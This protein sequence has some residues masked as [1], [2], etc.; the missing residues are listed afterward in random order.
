MFST[1]RGRKVSKKIILII[2]FLLIILVQTVYSIPQN[3]FNGSPSTTASDYNLS[4]GET[5]TRTLVTDIS[6]S[7]LWTEIDDAPNSDVTI[8]ETSLRFVG[9]GD[10]GGGENSVKVTTLPVT[11]DVCV[12]FT[13]ELISSLNSGLFMVLFDDDLLTASGDASGI[14]LG[15]FG[16]DCV[17]QWCL[18]HDRFTT[19]IATYVAPDYIQNIT[20]CGN[21][22]FYINQTEVANEGNDFLAG[23]LTFWYQTT[24]SGQEFVVRDIF[25]YDR[26]T[27]APQATEE[28]EIVP[29]Y[30]NVTKCME[31]NESG[32]YRLNNSILDSGISKC[33][34]VT[35]NDIILDCQGYTIDGDDA[36]DYGIYIYRDDSNSTNITIKNCNISNWDT[37]GIYMVNSHNNT[38]S[39]TTLFSNL[40]NG[41]FISSSN[42]NTIA[43]VSAVSSGAS[44]VSMILSKWN[45]ILDS[46]LK[47]NSLYDL[48]MLPS[49]S[50]TSENCNHLIKNINGTDNKP[51][52]FFNN[53]P[54]NIKGYNNN[55]SE[56][57]LCNC[58]GSALEGIT[59]SHTDV[60]NNALI[61][62][63]TDNSTFSNLSLSNLRYGLYVGYS[64]NNNFSNLTI[65]SNHLAS[66]YLV[67]SENNTIT[68]SNFAEDSK[69]FAADGFGNNTIYN[70]LFNCTT[71]LSWT[72]S[73]ESFNNWN[74][75]QQEG[76]RIYSISPVIG[77]NYWTNPT[78]TG[79]SDTCTDS[80]TDGFCDNPYNIT[81]GLEITSGDTSWF[82]V[83]YLAYSDEYPPTPPNITLNPNNFFNALNGSF[84]GL[85]SAESALINITFSDDI[86]LFGL[87]FNIS[88]PN[89]STLLNFTNTS[90]SGKN[91]EFVRTID[92]SGNGTQ[93]YYEVTIIAWDSH[94][95]NNIADFK[96][97]KGLNS[98][99]YDSQVK[100]T[101][102]GA[103]WAS[104]E[105]KGDRYTFEFTYLPIFT[106]ETK[107]FYLES[108][109]ELIYIRDS[110]YKGHFVDWNNKKWIDFEGIEG[111]PA[112]TKIAD[113]K[114]RIEFS[115]K[116]SKLVMKSIGGL[117][118]KQE[119]YKYYLINPDIYWVTPTSEKNSFVDTTLYFTLGVNSQFRNR[120]EFRLYNSTHDL[121]DSLNVTN[122][123]SGVYNY[124]GNSSI[125]FVDDVYY[126][127]ATHYD[128][129]NNLKNSTTLT[130]YNIQIDNCTKFST[131]SI[132]Y[133]IYDES[134]SEVI[135]ADV[136]G[137]YYYNISSEKSFSL[138]QDEVSK[139]SICIYPGWET[140]YSNY[141][142]LISNSTYPTRRYEED[143][144]IL[145]NV[146]QNIKLYL[147]DSDSGIYAYY[148]IVDAYSNPLSD[149]LG[150]VERTIGSSTVTIE[151]STS[152]DSG[153]I[154][155]WL[156][157]D[158]NYQ[159]TFSKT[160]YV[161]YTATLRPSSGEI[162]TI[163]LEEEST[164][165]EQS[166]A[167]GIS[168]LFEP[169]ISNLL[170]RT[171]Y[172]FTFNLTTT[173]WTLTGC[174]LYLK[175]TSETLSSTSGIV[176][177]SKCSL[178]I[179]FNTGNQ[180]TIIAEAVYQLNS[181]TNDTVSTQYAVV[182]SYEG[183]F[184]FKNFLDDL[185]AFGN[186]GFNDFTRMI[187]AFIVIFSIVGAASYKY[188]QFREPMPL[189]ILFL[190][191]LFMFSYIGW[192]TVNYE[193][194]PYHI[195]HLPDGWLRQYMMFFVSIIASVGY[196][197][198]EAK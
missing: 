80:D 28:E 21:G 49:S 73:I 27:G 30:T 77:G 157:P 149:V 96:V 173:Y 60:E 45:K 12:S 195:P 187:I 186:L 106:P 81:S 44:G 167:T 84:I 153:L 185:K 189:I 197:F 134:S 41:I 112:I 165:P 47:N 7:E 160:G 162:T 181:T 117:N 48:A 22:T 6:T 19:R 143:L 148:R 72:A 20:I 3:V 146:T 102:E 105:K 103:I 51:I 147:L 122:N 111:S 90:L 24:D 176:N 98:I 180:T 26:L 68:S 71:R 82:S 76:T 183:Q 128:Q 192:L 154:V 171:D 78:G 29:F 9:S 23:N 130:F 92:V 36:A 50:I 116:A 179:E 4:G 94:T 113:N 144:A 138:A 32:E 43:N 156:D 74:T 170:N 139:F 163:T 136:T 64:N 169:A 25:G 91:F 1:R 17:Y 175:N 87:E 196:F 58:D 108:D 55:V 15:N 172:N 151:Q 174:A 155:F 142:L 141:E 42:Y 135:T 107:V 188:S 132:N 190:I 126:L 127:N 115:N 54:I 52:L 114:W 14:F 67:N 120:T 5:F 145:T 194:I 137:T 69:C 159:F 38:I 168:Y 133:T 66:F 191:L 39:N 57:I 56:I 62:S 85:A 40:D 131:H 104:T 118:S 161:T 193:G 53:T 178:K 59:I 100:I 158:V 129:D 31:L 119:S 177:S 184:S 70:N 152:D 10:D 65:S 75:T 97:S 150:K 166:Y 63:I 11:P 164:S 110:K 61:V 140:I 83:D 18:T 13:F 89:G 35:A 86:S 16:G 46:N 124:N 2:G 101:A 125:S 123:G 37:A 93:G 79:Y 88:Y 121:V 182:Y 109:S 198:L 33:I 95:A 8:N 34:N 99:T